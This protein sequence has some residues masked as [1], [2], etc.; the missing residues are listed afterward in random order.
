MTFSIENTPNQ[1]QETITSTPL[2]QEKDVSL[3]LLHRYQLLLEIARDLAS[4]VN[5]NELLNRI[6]N[7]AVSLTDANAASILLYEPTTQELHFEAASNLNELS[8]R[9]LIVPVDAS[10]AGWIIK[11]RKPVIIEDTEKDTRHFEHIGQIVNIQTKSLLGVPMIAK[12]IPI[13]VL[14]VINRKNGTFTLEDQNLLI[15]LAAQAANAIETSRLFQQS[16]LLADLVH[17]LRTPMGSLNTAAHLLLRPDLPDEQR[18]RIVE[19][20]NDETFRISELASAFLDLSRLESGRT[21]FRFDVFEVNQLLDDCVDIM[22]MRA[23]EKELEIDIHIPSKLPA[24]MADRDKIKQV[25]I[26]LISNAVKY[27]KPHGKIGLIAREN[28][29]DLQIEIS[30]TGA[31][32]SPEYIPHLFHKFFRVPGSEQLALGTGLGLVICK[33]IIEIHRGTIDVHSEVG[34]GTTFIVHLPLKTVE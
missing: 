20:I 2:L 9:G 17:E 14:E 25:L 13:G 19:I 31:G 5:L 34:K 26:N 18:K 27:N 4:T 15:T 24:I 6:V 8:M 29:S 16:D 32:I 22:R 33:Q 12:E 30:D 1:S 7:A 3:E 21:Q 23:I 10:I 28:K 11:N